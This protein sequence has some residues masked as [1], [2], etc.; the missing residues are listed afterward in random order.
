MKKKSLF[1]IAMEEKN[2]KQLEDENVV[3]TKKNSKI[4]IAVSIIGGVIK[5][6]FYVIVCVLL[7]VGTTVLT[8]SELR[9]QLMNIVNLNL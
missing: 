7:T 1:D 3:V 9:E 4:S 2:R 8:N 6:C 5:F